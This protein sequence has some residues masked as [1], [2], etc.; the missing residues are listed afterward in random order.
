MSSH[1]TN[2]TLVEMLVTYSHN[3]IQAYD[4]CQNTR[5]AQLLLQ[6]IEVCLYIYLLLI[7]VEHCVYTVCYH[8]CVCYI[9]VRRGVGVVSST[10]RL[11]PTHSKR[12]HRLMTVTDK[13]LTLE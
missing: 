2:C 13:T 5:T 11:G 10:R 8:D 1:S 6:D 3:H 4:N 12:I 9:Q 7:I